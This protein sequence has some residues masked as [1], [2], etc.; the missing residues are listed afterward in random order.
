MSVGHETSASLVVTRRRR[1]PRP[2]PR[3]HIFAR[4]ASD[5]V[6]DDDAEDERARATTKHKASIVTK[7][8]DRGTSSLY[9]AER[10]RKDDGAFDALGDVDE[11]ACAIGVAREFC[12]RQDERFRALMKEVRKRL[13]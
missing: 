1:R 13:E 3:R 6:V 10:R 11:C 4:M 7:T 8:G 2:R 12:E 9:N 5:D